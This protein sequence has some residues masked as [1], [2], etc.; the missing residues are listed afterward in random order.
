M[1]G[2]KVIEVSALRSTSIFLNSSS[3]FIPLP[4]ST[5]VDRHILHRA[6]AALAS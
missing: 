4:H 6:A 2:V 1:A 5:A 3:K